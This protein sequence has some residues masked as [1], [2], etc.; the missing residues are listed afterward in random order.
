MFVAHKKREKVTYNNII[1]NNNKMKI[2]KI[3]F[4]LFFGFKIKNVLLILYRALEYTKVVLFY[5]IYFFVNYNRLMI[6]TRLKF[7]IEI[8]NFFFRH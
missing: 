2:R 1:N 3:N 4:I 7:Q 5:F 6:T 8:E